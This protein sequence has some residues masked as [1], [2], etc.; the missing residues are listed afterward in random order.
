MIVKSSTSVEYAR[1]MKVILINDC[2]KQDECC[3]INHDNTHHSDTYTHYIFID[4][5]RDDFNFSGILNTHT[6]FYNH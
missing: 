6:T 1:K 3:L 2:K 5:R 4:W